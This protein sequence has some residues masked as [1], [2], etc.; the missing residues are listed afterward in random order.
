VTREAA[1]HELQALGCEVVNGHPEDYA[2]VAT[3]PEPSLSISF[4]HS[5]RR[6]H[7]YPSLASAKV[8]AKKVENPLARAYR[9]EF[10]CSGWHVGKNPENLH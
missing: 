5:C 1:V 4:F 3:A 9:C 7:R 8:A 10:G 6:K 2:E